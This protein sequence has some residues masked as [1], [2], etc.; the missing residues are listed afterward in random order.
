ML[1]QLPPVF[2]DNV[3]VEPIH[4]GLPP[5][6][7]AVGL[8]R[9]VMGAVGLEGQPVAACVN[10]NVALPAAIPC[11]KP[12]LLTV[13]TKGSLLDQVP[14]TVGVK[15]VVVPS[16]IVAGPRIFTNG[17]P[18][19]V[20]AVETADTHPDVLSVNVKVAVPGEIPVINPV[21]DIVAIPG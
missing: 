1:V 6:I 19:T 10:V 16:Q 9:T 21:F 17:R 2:G 15:L 18:L 20:I 13:A 7:N 3:V 4:I 14:F 12:V 5:V 8:A 11:T